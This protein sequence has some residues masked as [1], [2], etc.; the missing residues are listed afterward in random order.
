MFKNCKIILVRPQ[1]AGNIGSIARVMKNMGFSQ[2]VLVSPKANHLDDVAKKFS[3]QG[4]TILHT[5]TQVDSI[6]Q[7]LV[8]CTYVAATSSQT[9]GLVRASIIKPI[10]I[11]AKVLSKE[12]NRSQV[13]LI[14]GPESSGLTTEEISLCNLLIGIPTSNDYPALNVAM[15]V[16]ITLHEI[17][18]VMEEKDEETTKPIELASWKMQQQAFDALRS[19]LEEIHFLFGP[20]ADALFN[21]I[22]TMIARSNPTTQEM[23]WLIGLNRQLTWYK[24]KIRD[25]N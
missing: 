22:K 5:S 18:M 6:E 13:A 12:I 21:G 25:Q 7:A 14:F 4:E 17:N 10:R 15:S 3:C 8:D 19:S 24:A 1:F 9:K 16:A 20:K 23:K 2:L 11:A